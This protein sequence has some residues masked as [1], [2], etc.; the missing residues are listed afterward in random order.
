VVARAYLDSSAIVRWVVRE[1]G[2]GELAGYLG[3]HPELFTSRLAFVELGRVLMRLGDGER[4]QFRERVDDLLG[5]ISIVEVTPSIA[6]A[7]GSIGPQSLRSLDAIHLASYA[8][9]RPD[10]EA[11]VTYDARLADAARAIGGQ[12]AA[13]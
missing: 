11:L 8:A 6:S 1:P 7:A 13:P 12:V 3:A 4:A 5:R 2:W 10:V 9:L